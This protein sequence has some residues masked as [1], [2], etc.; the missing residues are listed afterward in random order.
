MQGREAGIES[1]SRQIERPTNKAPLLVYQYWR[2]FVKGPGWVCCI[3]LVIGST[4]VHENESPRCI[5]RVAFEKMEDFVAAYCPGVLLDG[6][7]ILGM[8]GGRVRHRL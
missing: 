1:L 8:P 2:H 7:R 6:G 5:P 3:Y 4:K